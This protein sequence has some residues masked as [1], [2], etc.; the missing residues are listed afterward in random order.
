MNIILEHAT[1]MTC[2][3]SS[4]VR[5]SVMIVE[6]PHKRIID[7]IIAK[8]PVGYSAVYASG[9]LKSYLIIVCS[10]TQKSNCKC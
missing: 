10:Y 6:S 4:T 3:G 5:A 7:I 1:S 9:I 2:S 8:T